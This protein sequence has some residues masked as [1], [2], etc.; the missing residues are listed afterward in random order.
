MGKVCGRP[1]PLGDGSTHDNFTSQSQDLPRERQLVGD[2]AFPLDDG[3]PM[4]PACARACVRA[5]VSECV[6]VRE[7]MRSCMCVCVC[8]CV[9]VRRHVRTR[10]D[11]LRTSV[12]LSSVV[13][14]WQPRNE[15][16]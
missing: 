5:C 13:R 11:V 1:S 15:A 7:C 14:K 10:T 4:T 6:R 8:V 12:T 2:I 3:P 16:D 9:C